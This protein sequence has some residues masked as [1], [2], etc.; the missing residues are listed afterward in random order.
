MLGRSELTVRMMCRQHFAAIPP[1]CRAIVT[2]QQ[3]EA[4]LDRLENQ[5]VDTHGQRGQRHLPQQRPAWLQC[6]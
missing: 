3:E 2:L 1:L 5:Y 4:F 6:I